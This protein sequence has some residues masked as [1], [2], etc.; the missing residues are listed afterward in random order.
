MS[1]ALSSC[2]DAVPRPVSTLSKTYAAGLGE[3]RSGLLRQEFQAYVQPKFDLLS[4]RVH[5]VEVLARWRH[6]L[7]GLLAPAVFIPSMARE[8]LLDELLCSLLDQ[9]LAC[10]MG[11]HRHG[12]TLDFAFNL[13]L[14][15]LSSDELLDRLVARL[16]EHPLPLSSLTLEITEDGSADIAPDVIQRLARLQRLGVRLSMDDFGTG[17]SSLWR[18]SQVAFDE[19][20]LAGEFTRGIEQSRCS[21]AII[22]HASALAEDLGMQLVVEGIESQAQRLALLAL[23]VGLGQGYLCARPMPAAALGSWLGQAERM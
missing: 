20:K 19:I 17:H 4:Q 13:G 16:Y 7:R 21:R 3:L 11:L 1:I 8:R 18:L 15:Q 6:P 23:G 5:G 10:Q 12:R 2:R 9:G 22:R 14:H